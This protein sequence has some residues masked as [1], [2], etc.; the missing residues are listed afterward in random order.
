[1][2]N[3][4]KIV[5]QAEAMAL[6]AKPWTLKHDGKV[7]TAVF[8]MNEWVYDVFEGGFFMMKINM[9]SPMKAKQ[10]LSNWLVS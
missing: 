6:K 3:T 4:E 9:K 5:N 1:M 10:F 2:L 8:N 7:Y